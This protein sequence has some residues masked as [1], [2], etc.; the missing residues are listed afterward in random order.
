MTWFLTYYIIP[1]VVIFYISCPQKVSKF[2]EGQVW[3]LLTYLLPHFCVEADWLP[4]PPHLR[5]LPPVKTASH[6]TSLPIPTAYSCL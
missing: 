4:L 6:C 1:C 2:A 5:H 3:V